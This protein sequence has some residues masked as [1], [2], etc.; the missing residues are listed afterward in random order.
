[1]SETFGD[2]LRQKRE[3]RGVDLTRIAEDTKISVGLLDALEHDDLSHWPT[4][5]FRRSFVRSYARA[6]GL[7]P[8]VTVREFF[9]AHPDPIP[10]PEPADVEPVASG[11]SRLGLMFHA[12]T[13]KGNSNPLP[14][15]GRLVAAAPASPPIAVTRRINLTSL[16]KV[17]TNLAAAQS[18]EDALIVFDALAEML[19]AVGLVIWKARADRSRLAPIAARGYPPSLLARIPD[20]PCD[21]DNATA[22]AFRSSAT[23]LVAGKDRQNGAI[24]VPIVGASGC[25]GVLAIEVSADTQLDEQVQ[26][27]VAI[28][29][30]QLSWVLAQDR[31]A[32]ADRKL[33]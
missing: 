31:V 8:E 6:I 29:A 18:I 22:A 19:G 20:V 1:M 24:T 32:V 23:C 26:A 9:E 13:T 28:I 14:S 15:F 17:C 16:A 21:A 5:I 30:A 7:D 12:L 33:A 25:V 3:L 10:D 2:R 11:S 27:T 4:G